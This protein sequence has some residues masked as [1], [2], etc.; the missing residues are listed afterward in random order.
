[1]RPPPCEHRNKW[2]PRAS[3]ECS[4]C[5]AIL[6]RVCSHVLS[7]YIK[8]A[9][10]YVFIRTCECNVNVSLLSDAHRVRSNKGCSFARVS[11]IHHSYSCALHSSC[12]Y[13]MANKFDSPPK[14]EL[15]LPCIS[16]LH[17]T[18]LTLFLSQLVRITWKHNQ[19]SPT[20]L[21]KSHT[22]QW[23]TM[24]LGRINWLVHARCTLMA[25][26]FGPHYQGW[27]KGHTIRYGVVIPVNNI[28]PCKGAKR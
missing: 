6:H 21:I 24:Q 20:L 27:H 28:C 8:H 13:D 14:D 7:R 15:E 19:K 22:T 2:V 5:H 4:H 18:S 23:F 1:M 9:S 3:I 12:I 10:L 26:L 11:L 17:S 25:Q 16:A